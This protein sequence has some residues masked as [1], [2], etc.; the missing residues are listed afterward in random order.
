[1]TTQPTVQILVDWT[2][3]PIGSGATAGS[4][5]VDISQ[6]VRLD[7]TVT[8]SRGRQDNISTV[9]PGRC[10]FTVDNSSGRFTPGNS[11]SPYFP[12]VVLGRRVQV[13]VKDENGTYH[14]RFDGQ[15]NEIDVNPVSTGQGTTAQIVCVDVLGFINRYPEFQSWTVQ[16]TLTYSPIAQYVLNEPAGSTLVFDTSG[17]NAPALAP[18]LYYNTPFQTTVTTGT[19]AYLTAPTYTY[20]SG[21]SPVEA[22]VAP[23]I[24]GVGT[25]VQTAA[26]T[27]PLP[28]V[29]FGATLNTSGKTTAAPGGPSAQFQG[30][31]PTNLTVGAGKAFTLLCWA[32]LDPAVN[33]S[34]LMNYTQ[35][36]A[37]LGNT[38][39]GQMLGLEMDNNAAAWTYQASYYPN[40]MKSTAGA[41]S[42]GGVSNTGS[43]NYNL[44]GPVMVAVVVNNTTATFYLG[45]NLFGIGDTLITATGTASIP[46]G[47]SFNWL[48]IGGPLGGGNGFIGNISDVCL[49]NTAL[50][51]TQLGDLAGWGAD[52]PN[53]G[54]VRAVTNKLCTYMGV[55]S[56]WTGTI[57]AGISTT[58]YQDLT[59]AGASTIL[60]SMQTVEHGLYFVNAAGRL[61]FHDRSRR[62]GAAAPTV[63][64]PAGSYNPDLAPV[65][66]DQYLVNSAAYQN[67][68][69]GQGV[70]AS[71]DTSIA[72]YGAYP[73]G[74][75]QSPQNAPY[76]TSVGLF[77][78]KQV[79]SPASFIFL[80]VSSNFNVADAANWDVN[81]QGQP[82][83]KLSTVTVDALANKTGQS[84]YVALSTLYGIEINQ[85]V[86]IGQNLPW[87]PNSTEASELFIEG[88]N[89]VYGTEVGTIGFYTS[90][91]FQG[92]AWQPGSAAYGQLD[93]SATVG[94]SQST[95]PAVMSWPVNKPTFSSTMNLGAGAQGFAGAN[96]LRYMSVMQGAQMAPPLLFTKQA[97]ATQSIP[98]ATGTYVSWDTTVLDTTQGANQ[99]TNGA[100]S[101]VIMQEGWYE[102][103]LTV[104][105]GANA[106]GTRKVFIS[107]NQTLNIRV[108]APVEISGNG[109]SPVAASTSALVWCGLGD[110]IAGRVYQDSGGAL[111]T[112][113]NFGGSHMSLRYIGNTSVHN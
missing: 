102:I 90:P 5:F 107:Q 79:A 38:R 1:M 45:G 89:E 70:V 60:Q 100:N 47:S 111:N 99:Y 57:D 56:Y 28:S 15:I 96:D 105:F 76:V 34:L 50:N 33:S 11:G 17:N 22:A 61:T 81:T 27:S 54:D 10:T 55:P 109:A 13:N 62:M 94:I 52:G 108:I 75:A 67:Y 9:Q 63:T 95:S 85:P 31:L 6:Y 2:N 46:S 68:R 65:W 23:T 40:F 91:A 53:N 59:G 19:G 88:I 71:N 41:V 83:M 74:S 36:I 98:N 7:S 25:E 72:Q 77:A 82:S 21:N 20:Q 26:F 97:T 30:E 4:N 66:S 86:S 8:V 14:T 103:C 80:Q 42:T 104:Q 29:Q 39:T 44:N 106:T 84:E 49:Y 101:V 51:A 12:G 73:N 48:S 69:G 24:A 43:P 37:C 78:Q 113:L 16:N 3:N 92:R 112:A 58:D 93:V 18:Y 35:E 64:L 32:W 87:W 110:A